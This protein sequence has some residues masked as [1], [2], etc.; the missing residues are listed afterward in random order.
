MPFMA[1]IQHGQGGSPAPDRGFDFQ[2]MHSAFERQ[3][4]EPRQRGS[5]PSL[6]FRFGAGRFRELS[7][8]Q[9]TGVQVGLPVGAA[10][11]GIV[12]RSEPT[13]HEAGVGLVSCQHQVELPE[14]VDVTG[15]AKATEPVVPGGLIADEALRRIRQGQPCG[16]RQ[17]VRHLGCIGPRPERADVGQ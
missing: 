11:G 17:S 2:G 7:Q 4:P 15:P 3:Y 13:G 6:R 16:D 5:H 9:E 1:G 14:Q 10:P 12:T 8:P